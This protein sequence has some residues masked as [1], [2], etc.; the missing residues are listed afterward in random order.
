MPLQAVMVEQV[1]QRLHMQI[2]RLVEG[3]ERVDMAEQAEQ[4]EHLICL[5]AL[6]RPPEPLAEEEVLV[7]R[8]WVLMSKYRA[9]AAGVL[10]Y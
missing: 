4:A 3:V 10:E 8:M 2:G 9:A 7:L 5:L 1:V 6:R